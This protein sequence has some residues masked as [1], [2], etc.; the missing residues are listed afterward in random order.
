MITFFVIMEIT[1]L[2][3][4]D[5]SRFFMTVR[6]EENACLPRD[7][8]EKGPSAVW[9]PS[10]LTATSICRDVHVPV[11][12]INT[13]FNNTVITRLKIRQEFWLSKLGSKDRVH[14]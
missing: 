6:T 7:F 8:S 1:I 4:H 5:F 12:A 2:K 14:I 11:P 10:R 13:L 9:Q 3:F